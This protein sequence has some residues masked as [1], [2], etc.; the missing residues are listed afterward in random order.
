[1]NPEN[2][3]NDETKE[4]TDPYHLV[5]SLITH[6][7]KLEAEDLFQYT[8]T[9]ALLTIY[10]AKHTNFIESYLSSLKKIMS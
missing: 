8:L 5:F 7:D 6:I 10:L 1:M 9:A 3:V 2:A 4:E